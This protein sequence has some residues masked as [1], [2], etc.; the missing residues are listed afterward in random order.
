[1]ENP[2]TFSMQE[3]W[4]NLSR[5]ELKHIFIYYC[6]IFIISLVVFG[7]IIYHFIGMQTG[8][9]GMLLTCS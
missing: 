3:K 1:M 6:S 7:I 2:H 8:N 4:I 5:K 9:I